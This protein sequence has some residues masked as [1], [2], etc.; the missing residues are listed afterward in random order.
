[1]SFPWSAYLFVAELLLQL[2]ASNRPEWHA[3]AVQRIAVSRAYYAAFCT[4]RNDARAH[5]GF[6]PTGTG[7]DHYDV[8][9][10]YRQRSRIHRQIAIVLRRLRDVRNQADYDDIIDEDLT[11]FAQNAVQD[12][13]D[14][15]DRLMR[16]HP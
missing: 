6:T 13:R 7:R 16:L 11:L 1:M 9:R 10:H 12:A 8:I 15:L 14:V 3:E 4:A 2:P 5:E